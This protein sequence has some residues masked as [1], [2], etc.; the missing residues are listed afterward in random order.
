MHALY[1]LIESSYN[2]SVFQVTSGQ[3]YMITVLASSTKPSTN[4][5]N[6]KRL[7][8]G[9][10]T[11]FYDSA[12][13]SGFSDLLLVLNNASSNVIVDSNWTL[14]FEIPMSDSCDWQSAYHMSTNML[15]TT[16]NPRIKTLV[17]A[18][19][20]NYRICYPLQDST[21]YGLCIEH[22]WP[23]FDEVRVPDRYHDQFS[24]C[25][26]SGW[27]ATPTHASLHVIYAFARIRPY[28]SKVQMGILFLIVVIASIFMQ[29][30]GIDFT[31]RMFS[32]GHIVTVGD[33]IASFLERM[34]PDTA[35]KCMLSQSGVLRAAGPLHPPPWYVKKKQIMSALVGKRV[36]TA[37]NL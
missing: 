31:I 25:D 23:T 11:K 26:G 8:N 19:H 3:D 18:G 33:A 17:S 4:D 28:V 22:Q 37:M 6:W 30:A 2:S 34:D 15:R 7:N 35:R 27:L 5:T 29:I 1:K 21:R 14:S 36:W 13:V 24:L 32:S 10:W 12:Y 20:D 9:E 16:L